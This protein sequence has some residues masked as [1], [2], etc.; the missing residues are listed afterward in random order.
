MSE[1]TPAAGRPGVARRL[2]EAD[3]RFAA[4]LL[5][6]VGATVGA[7]P[8]HPAASP[9]AVEPG[10]RRFTDPAWNGNAYFHLLQ[11][12][13]LLSARLALESVDALPLGDHDRSVA[14][15]LARQVIDAGSPTNVLPGNPAALRTAW[16][17]RGRSLA[18]GAGAFLGDLAAGRRLPKA[19]ADEG[20][21]LGRDLAATSGRVVFRNQLMELLQYEPRT[22]TVHATPMLVSPPWVNKYYVLDLTPGRSVIEWLV[23]Q[24]HTVFVVSYRNPDASLRDIGFDDYL[25]DG[26]LTAIGV[27][28][29]ITGHDEVNLTGACLGGLLALMLTAWLADDTSPRVGSVTLINTL[30][31]FSDVTEFV[32]SSV[33]GKV[34]ERVLVDLIERATGRRGYLDGRRVDDFFRFLRANELVWRYTGSNWL[35]GRRPP[36]SDILTWSSDAMNIPHRAQRYFM[37]EI[38]LRNEFARGQAVL[39]GRTLRPDKITQDVF[40]AAARGDHIVPWESAYRTTALL[41]GAIRFFLSAGGHVAGALSPPGS[42]VQYWTSEHPFASDP[43]TW[44]AEATEHRQGWWESWA[45][46]LADRSGPRRTPPPTGSDRYPPGEPAPGTYVLQKA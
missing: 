1:K 3:R 38:C 16:R 28:E 37:R 29:D 46:W 24:G 9:V 5:R 4:G 30:A 43:R 23:D 12:V 19:V 20:L 27:I 10:D 25:R 26:L 15:F 17:T 22:E 13:Y 32:E 11:Q 45:A 7:G 42:K 8:G 2:L 31:D 6:T 40:V 44:L 21:V 39:A 18:R 35:M 36:S 33:A 14:R 41:P 34:Y